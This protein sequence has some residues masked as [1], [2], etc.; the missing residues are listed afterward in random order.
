MCT[1]ATV[2]PADL[3]DD[4]LDTG[5]TPEDLADAVVTWTEGGYRPEDYPAKVTVL[6][7]RHVISDHL[8]QSLLAEIE[9]I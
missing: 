5:I 3:A 1:T 4:L 6:L 8:A 7:R 2:S 9:A